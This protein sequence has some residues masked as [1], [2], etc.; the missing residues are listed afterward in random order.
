MFVLQILLRFARAMKTGNMNTI[1][2]TGGECEK[3]IVAEMLKG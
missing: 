2:S 1:M 3:Q